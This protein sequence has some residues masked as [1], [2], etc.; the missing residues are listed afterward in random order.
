MGLG[1][2]VDGPIAGVVRF[3]IMFLEVKYIT[4]KLVLISLP[5]LFSGMTVYGIS[6]IFARS[7]DC[8]RLQKIG[9]LLQMTLLVKTFMKSIRYTL[10]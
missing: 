10:K 4:T 1:L 9:Y 2:S 6:F 7:K 5:L 3:N 8:P